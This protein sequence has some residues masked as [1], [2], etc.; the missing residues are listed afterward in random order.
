MWFERVLHLGGARLEDIKQVPVA[1]FEILEHLFQLLSGRLGIE[2]Q[3][4][5]DY[6][7]GANLVSWV[8][9]SRL[10][11]RLEGPHDDPCRVGPQ[12]KAL[13]VQKFGLG[14]RGS[15]GAIEKRSHCRSKFLTPA[16]LGRPPRSTI[17]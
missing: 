8:Q 10:G 9:V 11:R 16:S 17:A 13:P 2:P 3:Y 12:I 6:V 7:I 14:Q 5:F 1:A 4:P 15:L